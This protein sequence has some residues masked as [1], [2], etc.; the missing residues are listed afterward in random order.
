MDP[1]L[2]ATGQAN[3]AAPRRRRGLDPIEA[4]S[5]IKMQPWAYDIWAKDEQISDRGAGPNGASYPTRIDLVVEIFNQEI[6]EWA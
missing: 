4:N 6:T 2:P 3:G 5:A 1:D